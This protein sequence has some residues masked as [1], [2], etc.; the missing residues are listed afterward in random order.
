VALYSPQRG[1]GEG[2]TICTINACSGRH[3]PRAQGRQLFLAVLSF[4]LPWKGE[5]KRQKRRE[6]SS[7]FFYEEGTDLNKRVSPPH[8]FRGKKEGR[9]RDSV[10]FCLRKSDLVGNLHMRGKGKGAELISCQSLGR[11]RGGP[12]STPSTKIVQHGGRHFAREKGRGKA[13]PG[14]L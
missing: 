13:C 7:L 8:L 3:R 6:E 5:R 4:M 9:E 10:D 2:G 14:F 12:A 11:K 1:K